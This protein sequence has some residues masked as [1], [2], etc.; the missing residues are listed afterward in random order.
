VALRSSLVGLAA[1]VL[2]TIPFLA[3]VVF[4]AAAGHGTYAPAKLLFP[5]AMFAAVVGHS[6]TPPFI[7]AACIQFPLYGLVL[8]SVAGSARFRPLALAVVV[9]HFLAVAVVFARSDEAFS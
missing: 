3:F 1:G 9:L 8:G 5:F 2:I 6:I 7:V 4:T